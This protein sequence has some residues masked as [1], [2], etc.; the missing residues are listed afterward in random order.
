MALAVA[1]CSALQG[2]SRRQASSAVA[3]TGDIPAF[4]HQASETAYRA[5]L[6]TD[7]MVLFG[8]LHGVGT[9]YPVMTDVY[10]LQTVTDPKTKKPT[11]VL[12]KRGSEW[13]APD[14]TILNASQILLIE[15]VTE[16]SKIMQLIRREQ[17]EP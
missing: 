5:V 3:A 4:G 9:P 6:L 2:G 7:G 1:G 10:Y 17:P 13:H 8:K 16:N 12:V 15:P 14:R 11:P